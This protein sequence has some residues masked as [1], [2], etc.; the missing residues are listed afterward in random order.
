MKN[1]WSYSLHYMDQTCKNT[2]MVSRRSVSCLVFPQELK[3]NQYFYSEVLD[4]SQPW[5]NRQEVFGTLLDTLKGLT[6]CKGSS[7]KCRIDVLQQQ[8]KATKNIIQ[9]IYIYIK[10]SSLTVLNIRYVQY[11]LQSLPDID[12]GT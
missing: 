5:S 11:V 7:H 3:P 4:V 6:V 8:I 1:C 12:R 10:A 2:F 9:A